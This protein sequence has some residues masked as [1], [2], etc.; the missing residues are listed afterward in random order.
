[1]EQVKTYNFDQNFQSLIAACVLKDTSFNNRTDGLIKHEYFELDTHQNI[2]KLAKLY[3]TKYKKI[4]TYQIIK[5]M[6]E[7]G[8]EAGKIRK[9]MLQETLSNLDIIYEWDISDV[10]YVVDQVSDFAR[11]QAISNE[12]L[13]AVDLI[14]EG[15]YDEIAKRIQEANQ[16]GANNNDS[17]YNFFGDKE[18]SEREQ[19][20][21]DK[22]QN[23]ER[24]QVIPTGITKLDKILYHGGFAKKEMVSMMGKSKSGKSISLAWFAKNAAFSGFNVL[25]ATLEVSKE[26]TAERLESSIVQIAMNDLQHHIAEAKQKVLDYRDKVGRLEIVEYPSGQMKPSDLLRCIQKYKSDGIIF[27]MVVVDYADIM[28]PEHRYN[29]P[30]ENSKSIYLALRAMATTENVVVLTAT[31]TNREGAKAAVATDIN[32]AEDYNRIRIPDLVISINATDEERANG[33]ARLYLAASR[34]QQGNFTIKIKQRL[35]CMIFCEKILDI[36]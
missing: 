18:I 9:D 12:I 7:K 10:D 35:E 19:A 32:V 33:E 31:Q 13:N 26:M 29:D 34:N 5:M 17:G 4:P 21:L 25:F 16:V 24:K 8:V 20:R 1:M 23:V 2:V 27:D 6:I 11:H 22:I 30:I 14:E 36:M 15:C 28:C 3:Y